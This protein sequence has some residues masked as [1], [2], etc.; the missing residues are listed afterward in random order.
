MQSERLRFQKFAEEDFSRY[1]QM[2]SQAE[3]MKHT[4]GYALSKLEAEEKFSKI[5]AINKV[6]SAFGVYTVWNKEE[7]EFIGL[8]KIV[9]DESAT[10]AE[11]GYSFLPKHWGKGY[12]SEVAAY[13]VAH[14]IAQKRLK[15]L[16]AVIDPENIPSRRILEKSDFYLDREG[17]WKGLPA[18]YYKR[19]F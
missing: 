19:D 16:T 15:F 11:L 5:L 12:G 10:E 18:A 13:L 7:S 17:E 1:Y 9:L 14:T 4:T 8:G 3:V 2:V 6:D